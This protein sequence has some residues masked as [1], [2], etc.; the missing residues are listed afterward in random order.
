MA[1]AKF[2]IAKLDFDGLKTEAAKGLHAGVGAA[3]LAVE[4]VKTYVVDVQKKAQTLFVDVQK[5]AAKRLTEVQKS[6]KSVSDLDFEPKALRDQA[7]TV[8][9]TRVEEISK[10][11]TARRDLIEKRVAA[12]QADA[13]KF[14]TGN[15]ETA[16]G[17]YGE[18][19]NRGETVVAKLRG[20]TK[21]APA[22]KTATKPA[23]TKTA[24]KKAPAKKA[25]ATKTAA[26]KAPAKKAAKSTS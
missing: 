18:L 13:T 12:L 10:E 6:V 7:T 17:T 9:A 15:V 22:T 5:D 4:T 3:D 14:V 21:K 24:A 16:V 2:D 11:T 1:K 20:E 26:K 19:A 8:F 25:P 23:A